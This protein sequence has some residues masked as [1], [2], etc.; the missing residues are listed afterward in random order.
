MP[1]TQPREPG[2]VKGDVSYALSRSSPTSP[3]NILGL[4]RVVC[5]AP[6]RLIVAVCFALFVGMTTAMVAQE[7]S[8]QE[9]PKITLYL[10]PDIGSET[11][12]IHYFM[13]GPFG[14]YGGYVTTE[15]GRVSYDIP[16]AVDGKPAGAVKIIA[17]L[18]GCE[19]AKLEITMQGAPEARTLPC[20]ALGRVPLHGKILPAHVAQIPGIEVEIRYEADW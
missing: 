16:A 17:Y 10:P 12:Q 2:G 6:M 18:S 1:T 13:N 14:G 8:Q 11:V 3:F 5:R 7:K 15:K 20:K 4:F 19:I 9:S